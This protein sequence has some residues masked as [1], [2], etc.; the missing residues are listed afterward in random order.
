MSA[1]RPPAGVAVTGTTTVPPGTPTALSGRLSV[2]SLASTLTSPLTAVLVIVS[3]FRR[4][5]VHTRLDMLPSA[6][7]PRKRTHA[8]VPLALSG[9]FP[10]SEISTRPLI[11]RL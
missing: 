1:P 10:K 11:P 6:P 4:C 9:V 5:S 8:T 2:M 7:V 3:S